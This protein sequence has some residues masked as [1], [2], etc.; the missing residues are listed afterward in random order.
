[1]YMCLC[2]CLCPEREKEVREGRC[3][4]RVDAGEEKDGEKLMNSS[5]S[6]LEEALRGRGLCA[7]TSG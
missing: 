2:L 5:D 6:K 1:M 4:R 7:R 3:G